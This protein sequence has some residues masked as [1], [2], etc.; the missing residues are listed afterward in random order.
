MKALLSV[1]LIFSGA[2][3]ASTDNETHFYAEPDVAFSSGTIKGSGEVS[4]IPID[5]STG[6]TGFTPG[7]YIGWRA[8][9]MHVM[10]GGHYSVLKA[11]DLD[12]TTNA[13]DYG[14]GF[15]WEWNFPGMTTIMAQKMQLENEDDSLSG[16][17]VRFGL[18]L[19]LG[20]NV[21]LNFGY[22]SFRTVEDEAKYAVSMV[23]AG[24]SVPFDV[25]YPDEWWR[26]RRGS[27]KMSSGPSTSSSSS[28]VESEPI[29]EEDSDGPI[30]E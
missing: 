6:V 17:G 4:G 28:D 10:L 1:I 29:E 20:Q 22:T 15:G 26:A 16:F 25:P 27:S 18:S 7:L 8:E 24:L 2:V 11:E 23:S 14:I 19:F 30:E 12:G 13:I 21:K 5:F 9:Y 3:H